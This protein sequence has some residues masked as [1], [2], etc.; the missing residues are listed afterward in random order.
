[1]QDR[2]GGMADAAAAKRPLE[3]I[4]VTMSGTSMLAFFYFPPKRTTMPSTGYFRGI[5]CPK[6]A[7]SSG[8]YGDY[9]SKH[10]RES[11]A[12]PSSIGGLN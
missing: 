5:S 12:V 9:R 1:M 3:S 10:P 4:H 7:R 8:C 6:L 2:V 11:G